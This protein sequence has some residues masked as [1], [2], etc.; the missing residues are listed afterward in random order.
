M[1]V[2]KSFGVILG[3]LEAAH[4]STGSVLHLLAALV[5][6]SLRAGNASF[7]KTLGRKVLKIKNMN[8]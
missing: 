4:L 7:P 1:P 3:S 6:T 8:Y 2:I 5:T